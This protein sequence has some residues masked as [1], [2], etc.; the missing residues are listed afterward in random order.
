MTTVTVNLG[1]ASYDI[2]IGNVCLESA[3][4]YF[5][6]KRKVFI[7][8]DSGVPM[9][10]A[11]AIA[12]S[13][14]DST[15]MCVEMSE[16]AKSMRVLESV[17]KRML[18]FGMSRSDCLVAV[19]G[20][21]IG[22]L[23]GFA[24][25]VYMR[26]IDF[27]NVPTTLLSMVDSSI[28]G[29][30]A[31]N[32]DSVKNIVGAFHQPRAVLIDTATLNTLPKRHIS[33]GLAEVIK[34]ALTCDESLFNILEELDYENA[35]KNIESIIHSAIKIKKRVVEIDEKETGLRRVL[36][37]GHTIGHAIEAENLGNNLYHGECVS[38][39]MLPLLSI[40]IYNRV[41]SVLKK[42]N[43]PTAYN[44][45]IENIIKHISHDK[46]CQGDTLRIIKVEK[47]GRFE[48]EIISVSDFAKQVLES[49]KSLSGS[50]L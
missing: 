8:T 9:Q 14:V 50:T 4:D 42:Y 22:D 6:L 44:G 16:S 24:A 40:N 45:K 2:F 25:S 12:K 7:L 23:G 10:Y 37:F 47:I 43:L 39:G 20:G 17:L 36:N 1:E 26:G 46:K 18:E 34:M 11:E 31:I 33:N 13:C 48:E 28:G 21:V 38:L 49:Q 32:L 30:T 27:Y 29:K 35:L 15:I 3:G 5:N 19:G 41:C